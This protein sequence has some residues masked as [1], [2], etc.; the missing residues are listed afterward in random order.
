MNVIS[1]DKLTKKFG[2]LQQLMIYHLMLQKGK[3][4]AFWALTELEK[5]QP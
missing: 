3:Y 5:P 2:N 1:A 4:S